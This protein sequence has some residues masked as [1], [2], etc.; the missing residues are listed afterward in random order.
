M[1]TKEIKNNLLRFLVVIF[2]IAGCI[3][4]NISPPLTGELDSVAEMI[5]YFE[6]QGDFP[7]SNAAPALIDAEEVYSNL[8]NYLIVD[9][10]DNGD[11]IAGHIEGAVNVQNDSLYSHIKSIS[12]NLYPKIVLVSTNGHRS[13]YFT[14]LLRMAGFDNI[15]SM[16]FGMAA[17]NLYF[18]SEWLNSID[19]I[20]T[21]NRFNN[22][23]YPKMDLRNLPEIMFENDDHGNIVKIYWKF[24]FGKTQTYNYQYAKIE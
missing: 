13:A 8:S 10:R 23:Y 17:W 12:P 3:E 2:L 5:V 22:V 1:T 15:Y 14:C 4:D 24:S 20:E 9:V 18:S 21:R 11:Y 19:N 6:S 16:N 7:N